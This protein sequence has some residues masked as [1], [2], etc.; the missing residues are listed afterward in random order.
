[1]F[2][3]FG[4]TWKLVKVSFGIVK[5]DKEI[6]LF[7]IISGVI[8]IILLASIFGSLYV[9]DLIENAPVAGVSFFVFYLFA[10]FM[11]VYANVAIV[12]CATIRLKGGDPTLKDGFRIANE[13][14]RAILA[15]AIISAIVGMIIRALKNVKSKGFPIGQIVGSIFGFAWTMITFFIIPVL[16]YEKNGVFTS[17]KRSGSLFRRSWGETFIGHF[18]LSIIFLLF[19]LAGLI[20]IFIGVSIGGFTAFVVGLVIAISY[21]VFIAVLGVAVNGIF[22]A[23]LYRYATTGKLSPEF[24]EHESIIPYPKSF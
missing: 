20:P 24:R 12:G 6:L 7:P 2:E 5:K 13:N 22:V 1:M 8:L 4:R 23:A 9:T 17:M 19:G 10:Y 14:L 3:S 15:W 21:W 18:A 11:I 16:I